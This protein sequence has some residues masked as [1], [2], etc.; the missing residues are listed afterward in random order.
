[1][2]RA[3]KNFVMKGCSIKG[4]SGTRDFVEKKKKRRRFGDPLWGVTEQIITFGVNLNF[5]KIDMA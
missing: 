4:Y 2:I 1:M 3:C 5:Y